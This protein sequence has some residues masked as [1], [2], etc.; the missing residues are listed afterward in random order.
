MESITIYAYPVAKP[1]P[2]LERRHRELLPERWE[3]LCR[4]PEH[5]RQHSLIGDLLALH[6]YHTVYPTDVFPPTQSVTAHGKPYFPARP[7]FH[8]SI[9]HSGDWV[10]CAVG[11]MPLGV[12]I[13]EERPVRPAVFRA[14]SLAEQAYLSTLD[15]SAR[16]SAFFD[17]WCL[18]EAYTKAI[19]LGLQAG[20]RDF[21]VSPKPDISVSGFSVALPHFIDDR[22][23]LGICAQMI[24]IPGTQLHI[25]KE[26]EL[27]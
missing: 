5:S 24:P 12:D 2:S 20:F 6:A 16:F 21:S 8:Y 4:Y 14:L 3:Q 19:G 23:H 25:L 11:T 13:Q 7:D 10:A 22:Y 17:I 1:S 26:A 15:P 9:S 27:L 18:K